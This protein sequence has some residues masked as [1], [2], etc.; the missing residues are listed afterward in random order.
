MMGHKNCAVC[1]G[2]VEPVDDK[3]GFGS[4]ES[5]GLV[6]LIEEKP[7][8]AQDIEEQDSGGGWYPK[9][10]RESDSPTDTQSTFGGKQPQVSRWTC[11]DCGTVLTSDT[12]SD[13]A[14]LKAGHIREYHPNRPT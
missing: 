4:C 9:I 14:Y 6:Y 3:G 10:H 5:C 2:R 8:R 12:E 11:P 7:R 13:L 1:G